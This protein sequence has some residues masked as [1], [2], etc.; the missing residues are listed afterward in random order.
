MS[1]TENEDASGNPIGI[2]P[3]ARPPDLDPAPTI[4]RCDGSVTLVD[5]TVSVSDVADGVS[6]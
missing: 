4:A 1:P 5:L 3:L 6:N 2:E